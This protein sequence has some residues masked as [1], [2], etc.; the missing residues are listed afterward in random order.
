MRRILVT[1]CGILFKF[2]CSWM[3]QSLY[4]LTGHGRQETSRSS[5]KRES[6][7]SGAQISVGP[8]ESGL[9]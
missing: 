5:K 2:E 9:Q 6:D 3:H 4:H 7:L 8:L 1:H